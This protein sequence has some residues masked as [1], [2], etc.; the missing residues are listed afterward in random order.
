MRAVTTALCSIPPNLIEQKNWAHLFNTL[1]ERRPWIHHLELA[2]D[3][4]VFIS[5]VM[6]IG[7]RRQRDA[8]LVWLRMNERAESGE[9]AGPG[10]DREW[11]ELG[12]VRKRNDDGPS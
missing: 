1:V 2:E 3:G 7:L 5:G 8:C 10:G 11:C 12:E 4:R 6:D 9:Q